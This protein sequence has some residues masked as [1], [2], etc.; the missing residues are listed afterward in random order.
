MEL[1]QGD[2]RHPEDAGRIPDPE[3]V[4]AARE[5]ENAKGALLRLPAELKND[6]YERVLPRHS[7]IILDARRDP[8]LTRVCRTIRNESLPIYFGQSYIS[9]WFLGR[10]PYCWQKKVNI[11]GLPEAAAA[12]ICYVKLQYPNKAPGHKFGCPMYM[13][14]EFTP[15]RADGRPCPVACRTCCSEVHR[16]AEQLKYAIQQKRQ[17]KAVLGEMASCKEE[18][19]CVYDWLEGVLA[20]AEGE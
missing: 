14:L 2:G 12:A 8:P 18:L 13:S 3:E 11:R 1:S 6:I 7:T 9:I 17:T 5:A 15:L 4:R 16:H 20:G 19:L 10:F